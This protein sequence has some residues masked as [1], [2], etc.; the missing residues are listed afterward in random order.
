MFALVAIRFPVASA[1]LTARLIA[2][3]L[4]FIILDGARTYCWT[5]C[6]TYLLGGSLL[7]SCEG[8][9]NFALIA[10]FLCAT[11]GRRR[12]PCD[13][14]FILI[15]LPTLFASTYSA[16]SHVLFTRRSNLFLRRACAALA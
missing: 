4:G 14:K 3:R 5:D 10:P 6:G 9:G 2:I 15:H 13:S 12:L 7:P 11:S 1:R 8:S 16:V